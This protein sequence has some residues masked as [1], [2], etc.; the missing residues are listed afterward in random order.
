MFK[1]LMANTN[2]RIACV[3]LLF[4]ILHHQDLYVEGKRHLRLRLNNRCSK[5][6]EK[7]SN[8]VAHGVGDRGTTDGVAHQGRKGRVEFEEKDFRPTSPGHSPGVGHSINN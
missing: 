2:L 3:L 6:G 7:F 4:F 8:V 1:L 5:D